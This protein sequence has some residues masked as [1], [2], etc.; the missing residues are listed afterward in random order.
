ML[1]YFILISSVLFSITVYAEYFFLNTTTNGSRV[2][3]KS[4][5]PFAVANRVARLADA[6][7]SIE[8]NITAVAKPSWILQAESLYIKNLNDMGYFGAWTNTALT[9]EDVGIDLLLKIDQ[10]NDVS[11]AETALRKKSVLESLY[12]SLNSFARTNGIN[13]LR[14]YPF[15]S[16]NVSE[17]IKVQTF[18]LFNGEKYYK[19]DD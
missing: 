2:Y 7:E 6:H 1:K 17:K 8:T 14:V 10:T 19:A 4:D 15:G 9:F 5:D 18:I 11:L 12:V 13:D 3:I 16:S